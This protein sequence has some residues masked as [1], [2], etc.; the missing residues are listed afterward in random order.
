MKY[1]YKAIV[2]VSV[3]ILTTNAHAAFMSN[4]SVDSLTAGNLFGKMM[5]IENYSGS[6]SYIMSLDE[7]DKTSMWNGLTASKAD[8]KSAGGGSLMISCYLGGCI[9][10]SEP[11]NEVST[12]DDDVVSTSDDDV[13]VTSDDGGPYP[14]SPCSNTGCSMVIYVRFNQSGMEGSQST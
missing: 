2:V 8:M 13:V 11:N 7:A 6:I 14:G 4:W 1:V 10:F 9:I 5:T 12:I 3:L